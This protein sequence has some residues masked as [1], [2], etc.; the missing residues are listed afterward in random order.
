MMGVGP[1]TGCRAAPGGHCE[2]CG[3]TRRE[4]EGGGGVEED[5]GQDEG[6]AAAQAVHDADD[7]GGLLGL[8]AD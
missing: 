7:E 6:V 8:P 3:R 1:A 5:Q 2:A 4:E